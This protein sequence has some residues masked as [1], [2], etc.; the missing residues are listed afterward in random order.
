MG[1]GE[2]EQEV[3]SDR[4]HLRRVLIDTDSQGHRR[5]SSTGKVVEAAADGSAI[6]KE[7]EKKA[8]GG[9]LHVKRPEMDKA[10][11]RCESPFLVVLCDR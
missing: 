1:E 9:K 11:V 3:V 7:T 5:G 4:V 2:P 8:E 10:K 6:G